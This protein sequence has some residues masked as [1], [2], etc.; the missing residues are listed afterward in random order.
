M[1][2][3]A[4]RFD[5]NFVYCTQAEDMVILH[6]HETK[7]KLGHRFFVQLVSFIAPHQTKVHMQNTRVFENAVYNVWYCRVLMLQCHVQ[8][9]KVSQRHCPLLSTLQ[10]IHCA[11]RGTAGHTS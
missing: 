7:S 1:A 2:K 5:H 3:L 11:V 10:Y 8:Q 4:W 6:Q 9:T